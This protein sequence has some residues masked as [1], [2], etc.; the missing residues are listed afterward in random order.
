MR[1]D[2][3]RCS[4][5]EASPSG[6]ASSGRV[7]SIARSSSARS[8]GRIDST[9]SDPDAVE[10]PTLS[11]EAVDVLGE[12]LHAA[13]GRHALVLAQ[14]RGARRACRM[15]RLFR[16]HVLELERAELAGLREAQDSPNWIQYRER[17]VWKHVRATGLRPVAR[18]A[19]CRP[20]MPRT[21]ATAR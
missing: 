18:R 10:E 16:G 14:L 8:S 2:S 4:S 21:L 20:A 3:A 15:Q 13:V 17:R 1:T 19:R 7:P 5:D 11:E 12:Y 9:V 6:R